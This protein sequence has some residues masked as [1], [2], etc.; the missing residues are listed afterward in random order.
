MSRLRCYQ[1]RGGLTGME[2]PWK[3]IERQAPFVLD[4]DKPYI[5]AFNYSFRRDPLHKINRSFTPEPRLGPISA[6]IV[7]LQLNPS[8]TSRPPRSQKRIDSELENIKNEHSLHPGVRATMTGKEWWKWLLKELVS[9][10]G[11]GPEK[12]ERNLCSIEFFPYRSIKFAHAMIRLPSQQYSFDLVRDRLAKGALIVITRNP[13]VWFG[14]VPE[15]F[16]Y[17][18]D[19]VFLAKNARRPTISPKGLGRR[20]FEKIC[21]RLCDVH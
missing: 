6:P 15:L 12:L 13:A 20:G 5:E 4:E 17:L 19:T 2:N 14:A 8:Y 9:H 11:I 3:R 18:D 1:Q 21:Q 16:Q 7:V 10:S